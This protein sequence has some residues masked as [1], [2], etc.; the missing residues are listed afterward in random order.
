M[1]NRVHGIMMLVG[2]GPV[3]SL[4]KGLPCPTRRLTPRRAQQAAPLQ[5]RC[6][7]DR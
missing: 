5:F 3:L 2:V 6:H 1:S 7:N 4:P